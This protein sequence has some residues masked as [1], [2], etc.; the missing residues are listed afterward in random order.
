MIIIT[1]FLFGEK[2]KI[3][4]WEEDI[5]KLDGRIGKFP[6]KKKQNKNKHSIFLLD[7]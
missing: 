6:E 5:N 3:N 4:K 1:D 2:Y 7:T